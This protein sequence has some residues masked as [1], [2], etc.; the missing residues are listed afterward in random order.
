LFL[1]DSVSTEVST[2]KCSRLNLSTNKYSKLNLSTNKYSELKLSSDKHSKLNL[3]LTKVFEVFLLLSPSHTR[4]SYSY[5]TVTGTDL[6]LGH[7]YE[8]SHYLVILV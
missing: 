3:R 5:L 2:N 7:S 6:C 1:S 8:C 4:S